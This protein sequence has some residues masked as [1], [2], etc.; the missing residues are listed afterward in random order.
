MWLYKTH[1]FPRLLDKSMHRAVMQPA[2]AR[3]LSHVQGRTLEIGF[4]T[5][6]NLPHYPAHLTVLDIVDPESSLLNKVNERI[7]QSNITVRRHTIVAESLPF[8]NDVFDTV[9]S[10]FT[11]CSVNDVQTVLNEIR[12]VLKPT[13]Q[14]LLWEHG[15]SPDQNTQR[16][17][18]RLNGLNACVGCG[19][20]L[21][22]PI[23]QLVR[24]AG[25][26]FQSV[27]E[28][29]LPETPKVGGYVTEAIALPA[30][31]S[32]DNNV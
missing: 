25:F 12:R 30:K 8:E 7:R 6:A 4:G 29:F 5:G 20:Q 31:Y 18:H 24:D 1:I 22:R 27:D 28:Y 19:C 26:V 9:V 14:F 13:G 15:L 3:L 21:V 17:Q 23:A 32:G 2:R 10:T 16:W 11:L